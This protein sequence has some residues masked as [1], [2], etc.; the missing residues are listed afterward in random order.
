MWLVW[1]G[2]HARVWGRS[3]ERT[4]DDQELGECVAGHCEAVVGVAELSA[5]SV[6]VFGRD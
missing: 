4:S 6:G 2:A 3:G 1:P 5:R